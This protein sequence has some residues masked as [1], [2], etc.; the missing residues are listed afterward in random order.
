MVGCLSQFVSVCTFNAYILIVPAGQMIGN[1]AGIYH[2]SYSPEAWQ[3]YLMYLLTMIMATVIVCFLPRAI[4]K[5]EVVMMIASVL[6]FIVS[7]IVLLAAQPH[8]QSG[9]SVFVKYT[10]TSGW[11]DGTAF[12]VAQVL[13]LCDWFRRSFRHTDN[14]V[15]I[16]LYACTPT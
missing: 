4:P 10:N 6:G 8:K 9:H 14:S 11:S 3:T 12:M 1:M 2:P 16:S 7:F 15:F 5:F 13:C